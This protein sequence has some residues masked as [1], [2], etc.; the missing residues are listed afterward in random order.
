MQ[1]QDLQ[2]IDNS[3]RERFTVVLITHNRPAFLRRALQ[4]YRNFSATI[5]VLD[6]SS[7]AD[8]QL[9]QDFP[10]VDYR[11]LPQ[12]TYKGLQDKLTYGVNAVCTPLMTFAADDDFLLHEGMA[13]SVEF[14]EQN[15]DYGV[16]HGYGMMYLGRGTQVDFYRR[17]KRVQ[18]DY[19]AQDPEQRLVEFMGQFLPPFYAV[20]RT[21]LLQQWYALLPPGTSFEW[22]EIGH[23][24]YLL[25]NAKA[26]IL[27]IPYAVREINYGGSEHSTNVLTVL[28]LQD[29]KSQQAREG[30]ADFLASIPTALSGQGR[31]AVKRIALA[32]FKAMA[33]GLL[34]GRALH[35]CLIV[36][37]HWRLPEPEPRRIFGEQQFVEMP[38]YN[39]PMFDL[40]AELEFLIHAMPAG[41]QQLKELEPILV[42]QWQLLQVNAND[43]A[44]TQRSRLWEAMTLSPF[45]RTVVQRL[46]A[47]LEQAGEEADAKPLRDWLCR[48]E[49]VPCHDSQALLDS[50]PSGRLLSWLQAREPDAS[51][52]RRASAR[53]ARHQGGPTFGILLLDLE[54]D[55]ARLQA[56]FD[57]LM[58]GHSRAFKVVVLTTGELPAATQPHQTVHFVKVTVQDHVQRMNE[59]LQQLG[60]DWVVLA[61]AGDRFTSSGLLRAS[62]ELL[63]VE[64]IRAL[65]MDEV[66]QQADGV[67]MDVL[68]PGINLDLLQSVPGLMA[69]HWL[70]RRD[71]LVA[72]GGY[73]SR[74]PQAL[75]YDLLLRLVGEA[76][77]AGLAHLAEPLLICAAPGSD[78]H[79]AERT[80]L[81][82]QLALR[83]YAAAVSS[84]HPGS[85]QIDYRHVERPV[86]SIILH[87]QDNPERLQACLVSVLQRTRY[88]QHEILIAD[89]ASQ[90]PVL[91]DW[92]AS[93]EA[94]GGR[95]RVLRS[96]QPL[97]PMAM[98]NLA[99]RQARG[100]YLVL[101]DSASEVLNANWLEGLL[102]QA[103]RPEVGVV[104]CK[105]LDAAGRVVEAGLVL[106][107][108]V[109]A[110]AAFAG[111]EK[112][113]PG[114]MQRLRVEHN[115]SAVSACL[116]VR[117]ALWRDLGG[118]DEQVVSGRLAEID[119]CLKASAAGLLV[120]WTPQAQVVRHGS[121]DQEQPWALLLRRWSEVLAQDPL[122]NANH[123]LQ[124]GLFTLDV[125]S[126]V[127]WQALVD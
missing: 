55:M 46:L 53:L 127:H 91:R 93:L 84:A 70:V 32:S 61:E 18:E 28:A 94:A 76:G 31:E 6:S 57:S 68:R 12:F 71:L 16:C 1:L 11:H 118:L 54:A 33:E 125:D 65:S 4:Y 37:S 122:Y 40:L 63:G 100:E 34:T 56:T 75:E 81:A 97:T 51:E 89:N 25:A 9:P 82:Q 110:L 103:Q 20:T 19:S 52:V 119:L 102:N 5:L 49:S 86:V 106:G 35:G 41:R 69:R 98:I 96:E 109:G 115:V 17:D 67:L 126:R 7:Q 107:A 113:A 117:T 80:V 105:L 2:R 8:E 95:V 26:R 10:H 45:N 21:D 88:L 77:L 112:D 42:R 104:G 111:A 3:L 38:F 60:T 78:A 79:E 87:C 44:R 48:L 66:Q 90:S 22:Q 92:L 116:M 30:F 72:A 123:R 83:G 13:R 39:K 27:P 124:G 23:T 121:D 24:F 74:Y 36:H 15:P 101:L 99:S 62:L 108:A 58:G 120:V 114:Y 85:L 29:E 64:G 47:S 50:L 14:L 43:D 59:A 73:D